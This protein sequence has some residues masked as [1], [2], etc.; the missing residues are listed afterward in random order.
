MRPADRPLP[1]NPREAPPDDAY[2]DLVLKGGV[3]DGVVYP[4]AIMALAR[5]YRFRNISGTSVG[6]VA[7]ALTAAAE[8]NRRHGSDA[9]FNEVMLK[10]PEELAESHGADTK[11][12]T[13]F[14]PSPG[15]CRRLFTVFVALFGEKSAVWAVGR[16]YGLPVLLVMLAAMGVLTGGFGVSLP[17]G[18]V[19]G[20]VLGILAL[21]WMFYA[22][23]RALADDGFGLC[24]GKRLDTSPQGL[25][26]FTDWLHEG[27]QAAA[28]RPLD[29]PLTFRHLWEAP[30]G[31]P[32]AATAAPLARRSRSIDLRMIS[33][34]L[35]HGR[36]YGLPLGDDGSRLFFR[37]AELAPYFP[38][39]VM[40]HL[41]RTGKPFQRLPGDPRIVLPHGAG[42]IHDYLQLP[43]GDLPVL[44]A[45]RM[46]LSFPVLFKAV[47]L[48][49]I[50]SDGPGGAGTLRRCWF[51]DGGICSN[52]LIHQFDAILPKWP[53]F[54]I[55]LEADRDLRAGRPPS[56]PAVVVTRRHGE[57]REEVWN[58]F[59]PGPDGTKPVPRMSRFVGFLVSLLDATKDWNDNTSMRMS[60]TRDRIARIRLSGAGDSGLGGLN[61]RLSG[62]Q[63]L[64]MARDFGWPA[65]RMLVEKFSPRRSGVPPGEAVAASWSEHRW[66]RFQSFVHGL[67]ERMAGFEA[68]SEQAGH[69]LPLSRQ[70]V[71]ARS[72]P[73]LAGP[74]EAALTPAQADALEAT[75]LALVALEK[76]FADTPTVQPYQPMPPPEMRLRMPL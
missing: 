1:L 10:L 4:W 31:T 11:L 52:F 37:L 50:D 74:G 53:T 61:L 19:D 58:R 72:G 29:Q 32:A 5:A 21:G 60:G 65:G 25:P 41:Q 13:L 48:Y 14:Q 46:S 57:G 3:V 42:H 23:V 62:E 27:I 28:Q 43:Q 64:R 75:R 51:A 16:A 73:P 76:S 55:A 63:I 22:D 56:G 67:R 17:H 39:A 70:I 18:V 45:T 33:T 47:P 40:A 66:V 38:D 71:Q 6:A 54:G 20:M 9:G 68:A 24:S 12:F 44:V 49:A 7:A 36:P 59:D 2:C 30:G 35:S 15:G 26:A 34:S 8:Y 69:S